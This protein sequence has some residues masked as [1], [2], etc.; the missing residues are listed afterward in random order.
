MGVRKILRYTTFRSSEDFEKW[1]KD[2]P[3]VRVCHISPIVREASG[4][5][6]A[7]HEVIIDI[8][9]S[10]FVTYWEETDEKHP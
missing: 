3:A 10:V 6:V 5:E 2:N 4:R 8:D 9:C 7:D 1:Q